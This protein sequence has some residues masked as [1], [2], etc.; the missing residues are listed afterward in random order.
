M[1]AAAS[2]T[3]AKPDVPAP[4]VGG[5]DAGRRRER[6]RGRSVLV[7]ADRMVPRRVDGEVIDDGRSLNAQIETG[8]LVVRVPQPVATAA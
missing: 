2:S 3:R 8:A 1:R 4:G 7:E 6:F 5:R